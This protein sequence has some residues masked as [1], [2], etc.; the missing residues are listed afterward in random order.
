MSSGQTA[1]TNTFSNAISSGGF[2]V[3][4]SFGTSQVIE[5]PSLVGSLFKKLKSK[6]E[7]LIAFF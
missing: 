2:I 6:F 1:T 7:L 5:K 3:S 4:N